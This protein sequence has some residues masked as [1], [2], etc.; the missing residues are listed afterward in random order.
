MINDNYLNHVII[1]VSLNSVKLILHYVYFIF[2]ICC[3]LKVWNRL[4]HPL[5]VYHIWCR[6][7]Y[8]YN[9]CLRKLT[10]C[11]IC[12]MICKHLLIPLPGIAGI[13]FARHADCHPIKFSAM[14]QS[15]RSAAPLSRLRLYIFCGTMPTFVLARSISSAG[16]FA[17]FKL[18]V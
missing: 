1:V 10:V 6:T 9:R 2:P 18:F 8:R 4:E 11:W 14:Y 7:S 15:R 16:W 5:A 17:S 13:H 3:V 12:I